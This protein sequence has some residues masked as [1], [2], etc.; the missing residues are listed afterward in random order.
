MNKQLGIV[1]L[2]LA[3]LLAGCAGTGGS[4]QSDIN[5][6]L[7]NVGIGIGSAV[8]LGV[9]VKVIDNIRGNA[10]ENDTKAMVEDMRRKE[11]AI[12]DQIARIEQEEKQKDAQFLNSLSH[13]QKNKVL[14]ARNTTIAMSEQQNVSN[15]V[16][17]F[18]VVRNFMRPDYV[19]VE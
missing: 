13:S 18:D 1:I 14:N 4:H 5:N 8:A 19:I 17:L 11:Q 9:T 12:N 7:K 15:M 10:I 2:F 6:T 3:S 16:T